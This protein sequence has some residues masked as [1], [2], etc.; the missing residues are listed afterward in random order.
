MKVRKKIYIV[1]IALGITLVSCT[2]QKNTFVTRTYHNITSKY[3]VLFNGTESLK[4]GEK[5][6]I[7]SGKDDYSELLPVFLYEDKSISGTISADMDRAIKKAEKLVSMHSITVKPEIKTNKPLSEDQREFLSKKEYN[8]WVDNNYLLMGKAQFYKHEFDK[9]KETFLFIL[10]EYKSE[11]TLLETRIWLARIYN[12]LNEFNNSRE[13]LHALETQEKLSNYL[14]RLLY[15]T[16]AD[17]HI[18]QK[19]LDAAVPYLEKAL[20]YEKVKKIKVR[21]TYILA[22]INERTGKL[23]KASEYYRKVIKMNPPYEMAFNAQI[24]LALAYEKGFGQVKD[25]E[26]QLVKMLRDDKNIDYLD[27]IYYALGNLAIKE[28][29]TPKALEQYRYSVAYNTTN[30]DQKARSYLTIADIYYEMPDYVN[31][32]AFY[33]S[34]VLQLN[35]DYP[36]YDLVYAKSKNLT[37]LVK[38]I[39]TVQLQDSVQKLAKLEEKDLLAFI[40]NIINDLRKQEQEQSRLEQQRQLDAQFGREMASTGQAAT[41][42][43]AS[44]GK[45]YFYNETAKSLGYKEFMLK[46]GNRR[47]ED[48]WRRG[49]KASTAANFISPTGDSEFITD[50]EVSENAKLSNKTRE[51]YLKDI[52]ANDSMLT[53]S[54]RKIEQALYN[55]G[56]IY[57]NDLKDTEKAAES[58]KELIKRYPASENALRAY[59]NLYSMYKLQNNT[60]LS[61]LYKAKIIELYPNSTYAKMLTNPDY[62]KELEQ[63]ENKVKNYYTQTYDLYLRNNFD[64]VIARCDHALASFPDDILVPQFAYLKALSTG[65]TQDIKT[66]RENLLEI[67]ARFPGTEVSENAKNIVSYLDKEKPEMKAEEDKEIALKLYEASDSTVHYFAFVVPKGQNINQFIFNIINFNLDYFDALNLKIENIELNNEQSLLTVRQFKDKSQSMEYYTQ[68]MANKAIFNDIESESIIMFAISASN[69]EILKTDK[70]AGRY[71]MFFKEN[72]R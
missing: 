55:M 61:E 41:G 4:K 3:N 26:N 72:Y 10:N 21:Y 50:S 12:H 5:T 49:E 15:P 40:D 45:W 18:K 59:Y 36:G 66:F 37:N 63:E 43:A 13:I 64:E 42:A 60:A 70:L 38:Q 6:I 39:N 7:E 48:N 58:F 52:P 23:K 34:A 9:A 35:V 71:L 51:F 65:R 2:T 25:I 1:F 32:Q 57:K 53:E 8:K 29:N 20:Q 28:G 69:L 54:H 33:D 31:A 56:L 11:K 47:L 68:V 14:K 62:I 27:Q 16:I 17:F 44:G 19:E 67:I 22:Q 30:K 24:S 46:W